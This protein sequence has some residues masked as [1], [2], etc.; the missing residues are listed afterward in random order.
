MDRCENLRFSSVA[1]REIE[2]IQAKFII[3]RTLVEGAV[4]VLVT[5]E[6]TIADNRAAEERLAAK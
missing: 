6:S 4:A 2:H 1:D 5:L 3:R